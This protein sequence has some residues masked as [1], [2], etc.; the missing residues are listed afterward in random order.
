MDYS[1]R[2]SGKKLP[3]FLLKKWRKQ[4]SAAD[5]DDNF[6]S[7]AVAPL[8][9]RVFSTT[10]IE[11]GLRRTAEVLAS[12]QKQI[13]RG[14][15]LYYEET[16]PQRNICKG[17]LEGFVDAKEGVIGDSGLTRG[18]HQSVRKVPA[19]VR[20]FSES[21]VSEEEMHSKSLEIVLAASAK[22]PTTEFSNGGLSSALLNTSSAVI[23]LNEIKKVVPDSIAAK[24]K[25]ND[26]AECGNTIQP[27]R[28]Q[29]GEGLKD[30]QVS[31]TARMNEENRGDNSQSLPPKDD[32]LG[33]TNDLPD[34]KDSMAMKK[35]DSK[36]VDPQ[37]RRRSR[38]GAK[39]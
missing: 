29:K 5:L 39:P 4:A 31:R 1:H 28:R 30:T 24:R 10:E 22:K 17:G 18:L 7:R 6:T 19:D 33:N 26:T 14:E 20:W 27:T 34:T 21:R 36:K 38:R 35:D 12:V 9:D 11:D 23:P 37:R 25:R 8:T 3:L 16:M 2:P 32:A 15:E 13:Y